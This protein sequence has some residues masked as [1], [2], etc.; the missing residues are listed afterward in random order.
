MLRKAHLRLLDSGAR[1]EA[2]ESRRER[3]AKKVGAPPG[4]AAALAAQEAAAAKYGKRKR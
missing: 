3:D 4:V 2:G 1:S